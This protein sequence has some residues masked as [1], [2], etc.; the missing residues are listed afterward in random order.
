MK[1]LLYLTLILSLSTMIGYAQS[2]IPASEVTIND[3]YYDLEQIDPATGVVI[4]GPVW[5][6]AVCTRPRPT[7]SASTRSF[8]IRFPRST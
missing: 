4:A 3:I 2:S 5:S 8:P 7:T 6:S 1:K